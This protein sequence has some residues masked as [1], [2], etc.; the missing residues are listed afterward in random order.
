MAI[1]PFFLERAGELR[2]VVLIGRKNGPNYNAEFTAW[3]SFFVTIA[4]AEKV[5]Q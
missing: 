4:P 5:K 2:V 1:S 3:V